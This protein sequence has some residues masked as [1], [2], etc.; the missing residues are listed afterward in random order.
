MLI[1]FVR[2]AILYGLVFL[3]IRLTGKRQV[4]DLQ[5][6]DLIVTLL[7]ADLASEPAADTGI[8][9]LYGVVPIVALFLV[10]R[11]VAYLALKSER[12]RTLICGTPLI[13]IKN[14][15]L[16]TEAMR[17]A[18]YTV[19]DLLEQ[20]RSKDIFD[21]ADVSYAI[22]ETN[23]SLSVLLK[24]DK[25]QPTY[26]ALSL[27]PGVDMP[28]FVLVLDGKLHP[29]ALRQA[30]YAEKWLRAQLARLGDEKPEAYLFVLLSQSTLYVQTRGGESRLRQLTIG[31][32]PA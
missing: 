19:N 2:T 15:L 29:Q 7:I 23:G 16:Q 6:F 4:S 18:R 5:P 22:L 17:G 27:P 13:L 24:G 31:G 21:L 26:A 3:I 8:P 25:Q 9:L 12:A 14:G 20:L 32:N 28:P 30:G 1:L 11:V 10:Q